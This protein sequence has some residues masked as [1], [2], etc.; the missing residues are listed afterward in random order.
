MLYQYKDQKLLNIQVGNKKM[1]FYKQMKHFILKINYFQIK[2][3]MNSK[4]I[5]IN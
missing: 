2:S 4:Q 5:I 3:K 1:Y